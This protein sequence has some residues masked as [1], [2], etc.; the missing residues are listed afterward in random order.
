VWLGFMAQEAWADGALN[1]DEWQLLCA[2][3][4]K[5]GLTQYDVK[6]IA[7]R[8]RRHMAD[9]KHGPSSPDS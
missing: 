3:G 8:A 2:M 5:A 9:P 7:L 6:L 4:V 1:D